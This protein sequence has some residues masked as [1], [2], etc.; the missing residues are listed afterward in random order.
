MPIGTCGMLLIPGIVV[1]VPVGMLTFDILKQYHILL[2]LAG[3]IVAGIA[4]FIIGTLVVHYIPWTLEWLIA[5]A[6][7][8][9]ECGKKKWSYPFTEGFGL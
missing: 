9:P 4:G 7:R 6:R 1:A 5:M 8:C 3:G 2:G